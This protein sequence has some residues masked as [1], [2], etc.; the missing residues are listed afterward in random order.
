MIIGYRICENG[1]RARTGNIT[2]TVRFRRHAFE[3]CRIANVGA[4]ILPVV[5][6]GTDRCDFLPRLWSLL[7]IG[8]A[9]G[10]HFG[11]DGG[12]KRLMDVGV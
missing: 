2:D 7:H 5:G 3:E 9:A 6:F 1:Q 10:I 12:A 8:V 4:R 11:C